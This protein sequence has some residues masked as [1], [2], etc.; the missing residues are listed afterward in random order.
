MNND[1]VRVLAVTVQCDGISQIH[2]TQHGKD[3]GLNKGNTQFQ[4]IHR[5]REDERQPP[6]EQS[7]ADRQIRIRPRE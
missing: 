3:I 1:L 5:N 4:S 6:D 2:A 7:T